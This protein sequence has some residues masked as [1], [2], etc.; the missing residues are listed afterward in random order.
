MIC[1]KT[2]EV[3]CPKG[4]AYGTTDKFKTQCD[5]LSKSVLFNS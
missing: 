3:C 2:L 1:I 5:P 4:V